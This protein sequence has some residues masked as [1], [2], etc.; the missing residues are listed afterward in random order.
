MSVNSIAGAFSGVR[1]NYGAHKVCML[2]D[3]HAGPAV[4]VPLVGTVGGDPVNMAEFGWTSGLERIEAGPLSSDGLYRVWALN[5]TVGPVTS[6]A[7]MWIDMSSGLEAAAGTDLSGS[8][9]NIV[10]IGL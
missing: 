1:G 9:V 4:Y 10:G 2:P 3:G 5:P 6:I 8:V 7:L